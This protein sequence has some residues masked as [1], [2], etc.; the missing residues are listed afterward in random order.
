MC[1]VGEGAVNEGHLVDEVE[2]HCFLVQLQLLFHH[3][4]A[5]LKSADGLFHILSIARRI[6]FQMYPECACQM[7]NISALDIVAKSKHKYDGYWQ[8]FHQ[9]LAPL[10]RNLRRRHPSLDELVALIAF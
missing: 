2:L 7:L 6:Y 3:P 9:V 10:L 8:V 5:Q 4:Q 1:G